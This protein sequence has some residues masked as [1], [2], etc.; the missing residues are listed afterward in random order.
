MGVCR[1]NIIMLQILETKEVSG[2]ELATKVSVFLQQTSPNVRAK[3]R[4]VRKTE[5]TVC[6]KLL[7]SERYG[8]RGP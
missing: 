2:L 8:L 3:D 6:M 1:I 5:K 7:M 4:V